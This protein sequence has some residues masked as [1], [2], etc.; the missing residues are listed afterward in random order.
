MSLVT[1]LTTP[2]RKFVKHVAAGMNGKDAAIA[3]G[4]SPKSAK[5]TASELLHQNLNVQAALWRL[6]NQKGLTDDR[7]LDTLDE[8]L[9]ANKTI[10]ALVILKPGDPSVTER[11]ADA[12]STDFIEIPDHATRHKFLET[13]LKLR[14]H[15]QPT[16]PPPAGPTQIIMIH[17]YRQITHAAGSDTHA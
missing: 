14:G 8:G 11:A 3:A 7:L 12:K 4:Y 15:L 1:G 2:Q 5:S 13:G 9:Q 6:M 16:D 10:S 17:N